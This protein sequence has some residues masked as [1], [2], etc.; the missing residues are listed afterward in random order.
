M[1]LRDSPKRFEDD[2]EFRGAVRDGVMKAIGRYETAQQRLF[3]VLQADFGGEAAPE[4]APTVAPPVAAPA[5][6]RTEA[7]PAAP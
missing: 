5:P 4:G 7:A 2:P 3:D 6:K 1:A